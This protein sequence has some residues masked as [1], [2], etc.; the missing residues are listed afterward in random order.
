MAVMTI[1]ASHPWRA[2]QAFDNG[3]RRE[4]EVDSS[5]TSAFWSGGA[6]HPLG[7]GK[8]YADHMEYWARLNGYIIGRTW[9]G[10]NPPEYLVQ[11]LVR[12]GILDGTT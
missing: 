6:L 7:Q 4:K 11:H 12:R 8:P 2:K 3:V 10:E 5:A 1:N 9:V